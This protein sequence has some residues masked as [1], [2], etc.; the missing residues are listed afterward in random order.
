M[1]RK[2]NNNKQK[3]KTKEKREKDSITSPLLSISTLLLLIIDY[4][5]LIEIT[6][7]DN[8]MLNKILRKQYYEMLLLATPSC[9]NTFLFHK[10]ALIYSIKRFNCRTLS[11]LQFKF[12]V[13]DKDLNS[14]TS[15][16]KLQRINFTYC[17][18]L[19]DTF[20]SSIIQN[21][22]ESLTSV[23]LSGALNVSTR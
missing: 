23:D 18:L 2:K 14:L 5:T 16:K 22:S 6:I 11:S 20:M 21:S 1:T 10:D 15:L 8:A 19:S 4:L 7:L 17:D 13:E 9:L 12:G 3:T